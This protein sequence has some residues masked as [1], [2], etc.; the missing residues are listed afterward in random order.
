MLRKVLPFVL[1]LAAC[2]KSNHSTDITTTNYTSITFAGAKTLS[3]VPRYL[4]C[5][6]AD[7]SKLVFAG[8]STPGHSNLPD[9]AFIL[10]TAGYVW[11]SAQITSGHY[12]GAAAGGGGKI[13]IAG[14]LDNSNTPGNVVDIFDEQSGSWTAGH[15]SV[16]RA[17]PVGASTGGVIAFGG[18]YTKSGSTI[19]ASAV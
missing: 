13:M 17:Y 11:T 4:P 18:G 10:D 15:L 12:E 5:A 3:P 14:G 6:A 9:T 7:G 19:V 8:G 16:A 1:L 2:K